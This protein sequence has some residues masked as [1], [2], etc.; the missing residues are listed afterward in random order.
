MDM[1]AR[2]H[3]H[4]GKYKINCRVQL[5]LVLILMIK[6][7]NAPDYVGIAKAKFGC[8]VKHKMQRPEDVLSGETITCNI[9]CRKRAIAIQYIG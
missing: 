8:M 1:S 2:I 9:A 3:M 4:P 5:D 6:S 7:R